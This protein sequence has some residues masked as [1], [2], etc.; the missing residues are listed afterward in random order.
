MRGLERGLDSSPSVLSSTMESMQVWRQ[1]G[2]ILQ[3]HTGIS[4]AFAG[5]EWFGVDPHFVAENAPKRAGGGGVG[6]R[7]PKMNA[8]GV[9]PQWLDT[10]CCQNWGPVSDPL[11][12]S[13]H[14]TT[15]WGTDRAAAQALCLA[16]A[17][18]D[19]LNLSWYR[20]VGMISVIFVNCNGS[21][22]GVN[23]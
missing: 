12:G 21:C 3:C 16:F 2:L 1:I 20:G 4:T 19:C 7:T 11:F 22:N 10:G 18:A 5:A 6:K 17:N 23:A 9:Q 8:V 13:N 14:R 15:N